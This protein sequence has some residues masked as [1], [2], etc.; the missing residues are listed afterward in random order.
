MTPLARHQASDH[1]AADIPLFHSDTLQPMAVSSMRLAAE[2][3]RQHPQARGCE[4]GWARKA[5]AGGVTLM[6]RMCL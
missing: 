2:Q 5:A 3:L 6:G 4:V 1:L